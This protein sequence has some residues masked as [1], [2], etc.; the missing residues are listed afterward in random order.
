MWYFINV[1]I[2]VKQD[3]WILY[4]Y[5]NIKFDFDKFSIIYK[6]SVVVFLYNV[7]IGFVVDDIF[8]QLNFFKGKYIGYLF[9]F[10]FNII[11]EG[12]I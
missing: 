7:Q 12:W 8:I 2:C 11:S 4:I 1:C 9:Y 3:I 6:N 10:V 5:F